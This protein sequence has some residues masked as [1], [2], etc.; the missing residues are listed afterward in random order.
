[1]VEEQIMKSLAVPWIHE[2][3]GRDPDLRQRIHA[4]GEFT[5]DL[6]DTGLRVVPDQVR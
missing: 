3:T 1:V 2:T 5:L 6:R 4:G